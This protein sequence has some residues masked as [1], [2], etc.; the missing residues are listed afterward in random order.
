MGNHL[1]SPH[2]HDNYGQSI[3]TTEKKPVLADPTQWQYFPLKEIQRI[4]PN[5][6]MYVQLQSVYE[7]H[8]NWAVGLAFKR[9]RFALPTPESTLGL[10]IGQHISVQAEIGGKQIM[11]SYTPTS[12]DDDKGHFDLLIKVGG[13]EKH[14]VV[15][16]DSN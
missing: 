1:S 13:K 7:I 2:T 9:Y 15:V 5:T 16:D 3:S 8:A 12:S 10:P 14:S 4:S 11:R 6:A